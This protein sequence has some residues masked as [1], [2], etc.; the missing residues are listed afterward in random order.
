MEI[1]TKNLLLTVSQLG[2][3]NNA[4]SKPRDDIEYFLKEEGFETK[5]L[6]IDINSK[7][8]KALYRYWKLD[9]EFKPYLAQLQPK[10]I[11]IQYPAYSKVI[12][13]KILD[14]IYTTVPTAVITF[15][16]HDVESL[17]MHKGQD[18]FKAQEVHMFNRV[19]SL[20]VHNEAMK[21]W[22][23]DNGVQTHMELL[24]LFDYKSNI[25][26][27]EKPILDDSICFAGNLKKSQ[28]INKLNND[29]DD[30]IKFYVFGNG[31]NVNGLKNVI[32]KGSKKPDE[33]PKFLTYSYGLIW[34]GDAIN[35]CA[36]EYGEYLKYN[37]PHKASLYLSSGL[38]IIVWSQ[39]ALAPFVKEHAAG[40]V[41]DSLEDLNKEFLN[42]SKRQYLEMKTNALKI[43]EQLQEGHFIKTA[44]KKITVK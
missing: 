37:S 42:T 1:M 4:S 27:S 3:G 34:D 30:N 32:Y 25:K 11:F 36:G 18:D 24:Q 23:K 28:F 14:I 43:G 31:L 38:P 2:Q 35:T 12:M 21:E 39:S 17:R 33:L 7:F 6:K 5:D 19:S 13:D 8:Q 10:N 41:V 26:P 40:L 16:V 20:I 9:H 44:T 29:K 15:I 22:L